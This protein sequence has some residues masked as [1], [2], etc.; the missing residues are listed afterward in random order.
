MPIVTKE[1]WKGEPM[2]KGLIFF[3]RKKPKNWE[4]N[5]T[6]QKDEKLQKLLEAWYREKD[7]ETKKQ[8]WQE[9]EVY[10]AKRRLE[11]GFTDGKNE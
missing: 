4:E 9:A 7:P 2:T 5:L 11:L 6:A 3:G 1:E 10:W 8:I